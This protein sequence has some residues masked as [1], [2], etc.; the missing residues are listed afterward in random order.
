[1]GT[2]LPGP[3]SAGYNESRTSLI[4]VTGFMNLSGREQM[5]EISRIIVTM[6]L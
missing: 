2:A 4:S 6:K 5:L 3:G 1:M